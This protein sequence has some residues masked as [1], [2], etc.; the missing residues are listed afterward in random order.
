MSEQPPSHPI[1]DNAPGRSHGV[2]RDPANWYGLAHDDA[3][4]ARL[5][6]VSA[7]ARDRAQ[8]SDM[9]SLFVPKLMMRSGLGDEG[10]R[11]YPGVFW[12]SPD[13]WVWPSD[14]QHAPAI[15]PHPGGN[16]VVGQPNTL[17][18]HVWNLGLAPILGV[19]VEFLVFNPSIAF[20]GQTP[21]FRGLARVDLT[22][23]MANPKEWHKLVKCP[24]PWVPTVVN[25]GH[26]CVVVRVA[27][28]GDRYDPAHQF[29]PK[30][31]RHVAQKNMHV[32][33]YGS[34]QA[35]LLERLL[36]SL[37]SK[38]TL[39]YFAVG[40]ES[41][42]VVELLAPG[43]HPNPNVRATQ[44]IDSIATAP[45]PPPGTATVVRIQGIDT[46]T[47]AVVGGYTLVL[48]PQPV[49]K[50]LIPSPHGT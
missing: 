40:H 21:L 4:R 9:R 20:P 26:E 37:P 14:P 33:L 36:K 28:M 41:A 25:N 1:F 35:T 6:Q 3:D 42:P 22:S 10:K 23:K 45:K 32:G 31:D 47:Q 49:T 16:P 12:E 43:L 19:V 27:G 50:A 5:D 46:Q 18:A 24:T 34:N 15:P 39:K 8:N 2:T 11:P 13:I 7:K 29:E 17:Y 48:T 44:Q 30:F 38:A